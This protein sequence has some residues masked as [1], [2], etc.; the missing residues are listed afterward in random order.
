MVENRPAVGTLLPDR[1]PPCSLAVEN[2]G[3]RQQ[4]DSCGQFLTAEVRRLPPLGWWSLIAFVQG[5]EYLRTGCSAFLTRLS[6]RSLALSW[7]KNQ[8]LPFRTRVGGRAV[9]YGQALVQNTTQSLVG[10]E[11]GFHLHYLTRPTQVGHPNWCPHS[12]DPELDALASHVRSFAQMLTEHSTSPCP[13]RRIGNDGRVGAE[14]RG[15]PM[16]SGSTTDHPV[17]RPTR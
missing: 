11:V 4:I 6:P 14:G 10:H 8:P 16:A 2:Q 5:S 3:V 12:T 9:P 7:P 1:W 17:P 15:R 13:P